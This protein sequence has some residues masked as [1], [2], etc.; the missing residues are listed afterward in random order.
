MVSRAKSLFDLPYDIRAIIFSYLEPQKVPPLSP[1]FE[2]GGFMLSCRQAMQELQEIAAPEITRYTDDFKRST[3]V[4]IRLSSNLGEMRSATIH[5]PFNAF[6]GSGWDG[7]G[8]RVM[9]KRDVLACLHPL[10]AQHF[11]KVRMHIAGGQDTKLWPEHESQ[12][13][14]GRLEVTMH[15]LLRDVAYMIE[16]VNYGWYYA[17]PTGPLSLDQIFVYEHGKQVQDY[18]TA[19]VKARRIS[20]SWDLRDSASLN[21][22]VTL[23]GK[24]HSKEVTD[25]A[26]LISDSLGPHASIRRAFQSLLTRK[27][28]DEDLSDLRLADYKGILFCHMRDSQRLVGEMCIYSRLRW[29]A[30]ENWH[31]NGLLNGAT[32][33]KQYTPDNLQWGSSS[34]LTTRIF[35][36]AL[37]VVSGAFPRSAQT[38][39]QTIFL[40]IRLPYELRLIIYANLFDVHLP[41]LAPKYSCLGFVLSCRQARYEIEELAVERLRMFIAELK[42]SNGVALDIK[43]DPIN[44]THVTVFLSPAASD[45][46]GPGPEYT[47]K[48]KRKVLVGLHPLFAQ[49]FDTVR[50]HI[51]NS[52]S[53]DATVLSASSWETIARRLIHDLAP[54]IECVNRWH[55]FGSTVSDL[56]M[57]HG[58]EEIFNHEDWNNMPLYPSAQ[59]M[60]KR[61]CVTW[62]A[63]HSP[64]DEVILDGHMHVK[65]IERQPSLRRLPLATRAGEYMKQTEQQS[66]EK[67]TKGM[68]PSRRGVCMFYQLHDSGCLAGEMG[69][70]SPGRWRLAYGTL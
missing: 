52:S 69:I 8:I 49:F 35:N 30:I 20:L 43:A 68:E 53:A 66:A 29:P 54:M 45:D 13:D 17:G 3:G 37:L 61:I 24:L 10:L 63:R 38:F 15:S 23:N 9:W 32:T 44:S 22:P 21:R 47:T 62:D 19:H 27:R 41:P 26:R 16:H 51:V 34:S 57:R 4:E 39:R 42:V 11:D 5:M 65:S 70:V 55:L 67:V 6:S 31:F 2:Y 33:I 64:S 50:I 59:V 7:D 25:D 18:P 12:S 14:R 60:A 46:F 1:D 48:W 36:P 40:F 56:H 58:L 28:H